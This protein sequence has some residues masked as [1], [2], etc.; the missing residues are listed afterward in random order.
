MV[1][2]KW[3]VYLSS[4]SHGDIKEFNVFDHNRFNNEVQ[5]LLL[6]KDISKEEFAEEL[7][8]SA[9]Y[10]FWSKAEYEVIISPW[11]N[12]RKEGKDLKIDVYSQLKMN[13]ELFVDYVWRAR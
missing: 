3:N 7:R 11:L 1:D 6:K 4:F 8:H 5:D 13:W 10:Y 9:M 12:P 2:L